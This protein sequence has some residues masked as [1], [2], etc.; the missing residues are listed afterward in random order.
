[1]MRCGLFSG[2]A[3]ARPMAELLE[4]VRS[5]PQMAGSALAEEVSTEQEYVVQPLGDKRFTVA[6]VDLGIKGMTPRRMSE[7]GMEVH[8]LP[9]TTTADEL[10]AVGADGVFVSNGPGDPATADHAV[11]LV[12][13]VLDR[14]VPVFGICFGNQVLGRALG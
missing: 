11:A 2:P 9:A 13:A 5:A 6:A 7:R 1:A 10:L 14:Q 8:V 3:A 12:R 4:Q